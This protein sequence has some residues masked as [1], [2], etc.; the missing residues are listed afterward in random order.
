MGDFW[1]S[2]GDSLSGLG[3]A[4]SGWL[5][6][7]FSG[8][9]FANTM[10]GAGSALGALSSYK[11]ANDQEK[12]NDKIFGLQKAQYDNALADQEEEK[13]RRD[14]VDNSFASVWG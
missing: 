12:F 9:N 2:I 14:K 1:G 3:E 11:A 13:E 8:A 5:S 4:A 7:A 10:K 6:K